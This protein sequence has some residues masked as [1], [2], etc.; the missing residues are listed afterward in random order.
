MPRFS[1]KALFLWT[2]LIAIEVFLLRQLVRPWNELGVA[3][4]I[5]LLLFWAIYG[6]TVATVALVRSLKH[7]KW[8]D[9]RKMVIFMVALI[10][11]YVVLFVCFQLRPRA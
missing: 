10:F 2:A 6:P 7:D 1:L 4:S 9:H 11:R 5:G 8:S 3:A